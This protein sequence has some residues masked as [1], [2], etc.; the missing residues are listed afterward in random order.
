MRHLDELARAEIH[1]AF[2]NPQNDVKLA[3]SARRPPLTPAPIAGAGSSPRAT[4]RQDPAERV[5]DLRAPIL[6]LEPIIKLARKRSFARGL[7][8]HSWSNPL[9][10]SRCPAKPLKFRA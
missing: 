2:T 7:A 10:L 6:A 9:G 5:L 8:R 4:R 1:E 3:A